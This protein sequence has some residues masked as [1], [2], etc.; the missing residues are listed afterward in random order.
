MSYVSRSLYI[1]SFSFNKAAYCCRGCRRHRGFHISSCGGPASQQPAC[2]P[3]S[4]PGTIHILTFWKEDPVGWFHYAE[5][6]YVV[7]GI[8]IHSYLCYSHVLRSLQPDMITMVRDLVC[9]V[10]PDTLSAYAYLKQALLICC[11]RHPYP[12]LPLL[13]PRSALSSA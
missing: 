3:F 4:P 6:E 1:E 8:P 11:R 7:A 5:A 10:T 9:T 2:R 12:Q 13:Q